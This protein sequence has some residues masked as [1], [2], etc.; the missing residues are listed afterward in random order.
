MNMMIVERCVNEKQCGTGYPKYY[1]EKDH[2]YNKA[3][4]QKCPATCGLCK[5]GKNIGIMWQNHYMHE[6][7]KF[8]SLTAEIVYI[9]TIVNFNKFI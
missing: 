6:Q 4:L 5:L 7:Y 8:N 2:Q 3:V 9:V 1:C